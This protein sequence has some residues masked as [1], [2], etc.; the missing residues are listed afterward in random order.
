M[1]LF[2]SSRARVFAF[3]RAHVF[4]FIALA[5][6][7]LPPRILPTGEPVSAPSHETAVLPSAA[8]VRQDDSDLNVPI[9]QARSRSP[10]NHDQASSRRCVP[11]RPGFASPMTRQREVGE[12]PEENETG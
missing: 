6:L 4:T 12:V 9:A 2:T 7:V 3:A 10:P 8:V 5:L 1:R 11:H